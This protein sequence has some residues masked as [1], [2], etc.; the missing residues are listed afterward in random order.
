MMFAPEKAKEGEVYTPREVIRLLVEILDP[1]P[2]YKI[3]DP[4]AGSGG[5]LIISYKYVEEKYGREE[6]DKLF[7]FGQE[8]N[9][10]Q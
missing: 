6:A 5:M 2:G 8:A 9:P 10:K 4:A 3:L 1:K 7:L